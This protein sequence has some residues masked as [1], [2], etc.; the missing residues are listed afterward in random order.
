MQKITWNTEK[1]KVS[2]LKEYSKNPRKMSKEQF[3]QLVSSIEKFDYV[4]LVAIDLDNT[5]VAGH[6]RVK[7]LRKLKRNK[8]EIEVRVPS[9]KL[10]DKE[11]EEYLIRSNLNTG[12]WGWDELANEFDPLDLLSYGF[13]EEQLIGM[14]KEVEEIS[15]EEK[16]SSKKKKECP[17]CGHEF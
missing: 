8:E 4:E 9:R 12:E 1:R 13:T 10:T 15:S 16:I 6:M 3:E 7:A 17:N 14:D 11:F 2:E 5:I